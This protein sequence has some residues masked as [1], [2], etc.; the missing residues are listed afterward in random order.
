MSTSLSSTKLVVVMDLAR[1]PATWN[2]A[3]MYC[4]VRQSSINGNILISSKLIDRSIDKLSWLYSWVHALDVDLLKSQ[5]DIREYQQYI[6]N[7]RGKLHGHPYV[8]W[9]LSYQSYECKMEI[10]FEEYTSDMHVLFFKKTEL[11]I[12]IFFLKSRN[13]Y[14]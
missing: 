12:I 10:G 11:G 5:W 4:N 9:M 8:F 3:R 7:G 1:T 13:G 6:D 14:Y 2:G